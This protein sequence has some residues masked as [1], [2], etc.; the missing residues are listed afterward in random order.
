MFAEPPSIKR[1]KNERNKKAAIGQVFSALGNASSKVDE[2]RSSSNESG[3]LSE[4][5]NSDA[6]KQ[7]NIEAE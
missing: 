3:N 4:M 6:D 7:S 5:D 1:F 2:M